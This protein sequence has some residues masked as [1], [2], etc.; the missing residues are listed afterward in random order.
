MT[1]RPYPIQGNCYLALFVYS[2]QDPSEAAQSE[3]AVDERYH[4]CKGAEPIP[5]EAITR[6][7]NQTVSAVI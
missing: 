1:S 2:M 7:S 4:D 6:A 3:N 5:C